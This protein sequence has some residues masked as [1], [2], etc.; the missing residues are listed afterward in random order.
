MNSPVE[1]APGA[2]AVADAGMLLGDLDPV[3]ITPA[4]AIKLNKEAGAI[5]EHRSIAEL[6]IRQRDTVLEQLVRN[7]ADKPESWRERYADA[8]NAGLIETA[9]RIVVAAPPSEDRDT[10]LRLAEALMRREWRR[11][12]PLL[13]YFLDSTPLKDPDRA[14]W[15]STIGLINLFHLSDPVEA[16]ALI[17]RALTIAPEA[18][19]SVFAQGEL[20]A[21]GNQPEKNALAED[22][23]LRADTLAGGDSSEPITALGQR[24]LK[25]GSLAE[26]EQLFNRATR[27]GS[28]PTEGYVALIN[29]AG[30][31]QL[32]ADRR[33]RIAELVD[34]TCFLALSSRDRIDAFVAAA[35]AA[36]DNGAFDEADDWFSKASEHDPLRIDLYLLRA[37]R[38]RENGRFDIALECVKQARSLD[39]TAPETDWAF[40]LL[41]QA[42]GE[43]PRML[44]EAMLAVEH[45]P[46]WL[47]TITTILEQVAGRL[48]DMPP[49]MSADMAEAILVRL[50][51]ANGAAYEARHLNLLGNL[52]FWQSRYADAAQCYAGAAKSN[53]DEPQYF[54]NFA[55]AAER[56][57]S[58][59]GEG[60]AIEAVDKAIRLRGDPEDHALR[61]RLVQAGRIIKQYGAGAE[62]LRPSTLRIRVHLPASHSAQVTEN[63]EA[64][65]NAT[66]QASIVNLRQSIKG[67]YGFTLCG[68]NFRE[69]VGDSD[70]LLAIDMGGVRVLERSV[71]GVDLDVLAVVAETVRANLPLAFGHDE[72]Q[73]CA[74][75]CSKGE[76]FRYNAARL[77]GLA[78]AIRQWISKHAEL[79]D[80]DLAEMV[81]SAL[82]LGPVNAHTA[83]IDSDLIRL[84]DLP[85]SPEM[86]QEEVFN[87]SGVLLP[88]SEAS[89][90]GKAYLDLDHLADLLEQSGLYFG[91]QSVRD[92]APQLVMVA[93]GLLGDT[94]VSTLQAEVRAGRSIHNLLTTLERVLLPSPWPDGRSAPA[95]TPPLSQ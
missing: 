16:T 49:A 12:V 53:P 52:R 6:L 13:G 7:A 30:H 55:A 67:A 14:T 84:L 75:A 19:Y 15:I 23:Y 32:Y 76:E 37:D 5:I 34:L 85:E 38:A 94:L 44:D 29:L 71:A 61:Q 72:A 82:E 63:D 86:V 73:S 18:W 57:L 31:R 91:M 92:V 66:A 25:E 42:Q 62:R 68:I 8:L 65:L 45:Q 90:L 20:I 59:V 24:H 41:A 81:E 83:T 39:P 35:Q 36:A 93:T 47:D 70:G 33:R 60:P 51:T 87:R 88:L 27:C 54:A 50:R 74:D 40:A 80:E 43:W 22:A 28:F 78:S 3:A 95:A 1:L 10:F 9:R 46:G 64:K 79:T 58:V 77:N 26:A 4:L 56:D 2:E 21:E 11:A 48:Y 69:E 17:E 89:D